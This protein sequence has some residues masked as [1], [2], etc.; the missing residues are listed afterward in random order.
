MSGM[1]KFAQRAAVWAALPAALACAGCAPLAPLPSRADLAPTV[2]LPL[3]MSGVADERRLFAALFAQELRAGAAARIGDDS[4]LHRA[5]PGA[6]DRGDRLAVIA[7]AFA[8]RGAATSVLLLPGLFGDCFDTQSVPFGDGVTRSRE[9]SLTEAY[10]Q[11]DDL[12]LQGIR[13]LPLPGRAAS[14]ENGRVVADAIRSEAARP[15][16]GRI[17]LVAYSK[18]VADALHALALLQA[19]GGVPASVTALVAVAGVVMGTPFADHFER[20]FEDLSPLVQPF[21]CSP[22]DGREVASVTRRERVA[23][24]AANPPPAGLRYYSIVAHA[25]RDEIGLALQPFHAA[26]SAYDL[27]NDGQ[28]YASD[29]VL[30]GSTLLAEARADHWDVALPRDRHPN[31]AMRALTS[32]RGYPREALFRATIKWVVGSE[33]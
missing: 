2:T 14:I 31:A 18:G 17:V 30:P 23:W 13:S 1:L 8:A 28:L 7:T 6:D 19:Q 32:G 16:V 3:S 25:P 11:Y 4:W 24:L 27:R 5:P 12:G 10:R 33:P 20:V 22:S 15:G 29:T 9:R 26:M 21:D